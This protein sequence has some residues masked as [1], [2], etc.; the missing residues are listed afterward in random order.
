M[1]LEILSYDCRIDLYNLVELIR[2]NIQNSSIKNYCNSVIEK[3]NQTVVALKKV[4]D[5]PSYGLNIYF[6]KHWI[7]Y[8]KYLIL[9][10]IPGP[11]EDL[12]FSK[13]TSWDE[14][15]RMTTL[16][17]ILSHNT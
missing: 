6:P 2:D 7:M 17:Q 1:P 9:G 11:Y 10:K 3:M 13:N 12:C 14:F 8:N 4:K 5:D 16:Y 15:L